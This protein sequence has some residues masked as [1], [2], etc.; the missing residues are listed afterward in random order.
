MYELLSSS[1]TSFYPKVFGEEKTEENYQGFA[2]YSPFL[3][4]RLILVTLFAEVMA[5]I[6]VL[7]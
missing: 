7:A 4:S 2:I 1:V 5:S 3:N 6:C